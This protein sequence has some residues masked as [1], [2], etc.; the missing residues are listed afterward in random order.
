MRAKESIIQQLQEEAI[1]PRIS[2]SDLLRKSKVVAVKLGLKD[3]LEWIEKELNGYRVEPGGELPAYRFV[4]GEIKAWNPYHGWQ[5]I[6]FEDLEDAKLA[7]KR[8]ITSPIGELDNITKSKEGGDIL[9]GLGPD[10]EQMIYNA[11]GTFTSIRFKASKSAVIGIIEAVRN[12][13][14]DW[15]LRLEQGGILGEGLSFSKEE[16]EKAGGSSLIH[17][18]NIGSFAGFIGDTSNLGNIKIN[19]VNLDSKAE[20]RDFINQAKRYIPQIDLGETDKRQVEH[21]LDE[22]DNEINLDKPRQ[23]KI[24]DLLSSIKDILKQA[25]GNLV[26]HGIIQ[27]IDKFIG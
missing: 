1:N 19:Q 4:A 13:V 2:V 8:G 22:L 3:F 5:P 16:H 20:L 21:K 26:A 11:I 12:I 6:I 23:S 7:S 15:S 27:A 9:I 17:I 25:A 14:L 10:A 24:K 18:G